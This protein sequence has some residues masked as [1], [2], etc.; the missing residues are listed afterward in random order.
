MPEPE[1]G[2]ETKREELYEALQ[3]E[4][5]SRIAACEAEIQP[6]LARH[7]LVLT[8]RAFVDPNGLVLAKPVLVPHEGT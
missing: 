4:M 1:N 2:T 8:A 6:I 3:E 5:Q 7:N